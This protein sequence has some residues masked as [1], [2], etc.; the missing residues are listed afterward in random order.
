[1][2]LCEGGVGAGLFNVLGKSRCVA[3]QLRGLLRRSI[4]EAE[5]EAGRYACHSYHVLT[6]CWRYGSTHL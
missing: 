6:M 2:H 3:S 1:M 4:D 5:Q